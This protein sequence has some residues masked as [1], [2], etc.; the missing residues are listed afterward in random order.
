MPKPK[1]SKQKRRA[2]EARA[3]AAREEAARQAVEALATL[4]ICAAVMLM[5]NKA[6]RGR[7]VMAACQARRRMLLRSAQALARESSRAEASGSPAGA[8]LWEAAKLAAAWAAGAEQA[9]DAA[10][11]VT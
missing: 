8:V 10:R 5:H 11:A 6:L 3:E 1:K 2:A 4:A 9:Y 7:M